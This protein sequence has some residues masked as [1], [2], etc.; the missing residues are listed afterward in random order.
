M[1]AAFQHTQADLPATPQAAGPAAG[2]PPELPD[3]APRPAASGSQELAE[4]VGWMALSLGVLSALNFV[5]VR[6]GYLD[7]ATARLLGELTFLVLTL[8][9]VMRALRRTDLMARQV[10]EQADL[11][12]SVLN[13]TQANITLLAPIRNAAGRTTDFRYI[14]TN[15]ANERTTGR[16]ASE[17]QQSTLLTLFPGIEQTD[18]FAKLRHTAQTG[19]PTH[20]LFP[21]QQDGINGWFDITFKKQGD[22]VLFTSLDVTELKRQ[23]QALQKAEV[24]QQS[25]AR[26]HA[27]LMQAPVAIAIFRGVELTIELANDEHLRFW[28]R[29]AAEVIGRPVFEAIPEATGQGYEAI[30]ERVLQTGQPYTA[31]EQYVE[32]N[33]HGQREDIWVDVTYQPLREGDTVTGVME[34]V[35]DCTAQVLARQQ[36]EAVVAERTQLLQQA[37]AELTRS[38]EHL[39]QFAYVASHDLQEPLRKIQSFGNMIAQQYQT[40]LGPTGQ[41]MLRRMQNAASRMSQLVH[42]LLAY[43]RLATQQQ[44]FQPVP[45]QA[46]VEAVLCDNELTIRTR[47]AQVEV[48]TLP[49]LPA[50]PSQMQQLFSNLI[51]NALK[52][53]SPGTVPQVRIACR[54]IA[55][56]ELPTGLLLP[57]KAGESMRHCHEISVTDNGIGFDEQYLD[58]IFGMF[59]RLVGRSQYE[60]SGMG[61]AICKRVVDNHGG[62]I[63]AR[64]TPGQGST[65]VVYL[66]G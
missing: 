47:Q 37:N 16:T 33:R 65:F 41:D 54:H 51:G 9:F 2:P 3:A 52:Y 10:T 50:D 34:V 4:L 56:T 8:I 36:I 28:G 15:P 55:I 5:A 60:G 43:S 26:L 21:Y 11:M 31:Q 57:P 1:N 14:F 42:D 63:T 58:R 23:Q 45:L 27:L 39:Q 24:R 25:E 48:G 59:Q 13:N 66:P 6:N 44:P 53:V 64:S 61:L 20:L 35:H 40:E 62:A 19:E 7:A 22:N 30:F 12:A 32:L 38:N 29:T 49:T 46:V 18:F 17:M